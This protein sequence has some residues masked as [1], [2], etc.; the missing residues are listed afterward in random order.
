MYG[1]SLSAAK[2][3]I[4]LVG[5]ET[6]N[7][8]AFLRTVA[9]TAALVERTDNE[10]DLPTDKLSTLVIDVVMERLKDELHARER[11]AGVK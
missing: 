10:E 11:K 2:R 8:V 6:L 3:E 4:E 7:D 9:R 1:L 5:W